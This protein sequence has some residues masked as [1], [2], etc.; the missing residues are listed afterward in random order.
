MRGSLLGPVSLLGGG[1]SWFSFNVEAG[2]LL[3]GV[4]CWGRSHSW[5]GVIVGAS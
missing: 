1:H 4:H 3:H 5:A 2:P